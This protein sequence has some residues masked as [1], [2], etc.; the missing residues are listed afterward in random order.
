MVGKARSNGMYC[1]FLLSIGPT[2]MVMVGRGE[3][4]EG[5]D[6]STSSKVER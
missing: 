6:I 5:A 3:E 4:E 1:L 2:Q